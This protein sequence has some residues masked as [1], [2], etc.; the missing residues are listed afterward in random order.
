MTEIL[1]IYKESFFNHHWGADFA[2]QIISVFIILAIAIAALRLIGKKSIAQ[3]TLP[4]V[5]FV[6]I[7]TTTLGALITQPQALFI[8]IVITILIAL[9]IYIIELLQIKVDLIEFIFVG[10]PALL[11]K[12]GK[13]QTKQLKKSKMTLDM[14]E[15]QIRVK[16]IPSIAAC[17]TV[18][19]EPN[20][21]IGVE[22]F[23]EYEGIKK[24]YFDAAVKQIL[25]AINGSKYKEAEI[26]K[27][28][29]I[30]D[31]VRGEK[32]NPPKNL[33]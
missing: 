18:T 26:P 2:V 20:G 29:N 13:P 9:I 16:G 22:T 24:I 30:F 3:L 32:T 11:V 14:L 1:N 17:K 7:L 27:I 5:V 12:D 31:E 33:E 8:G 4:N 21:T 10:R 28:V 15:S 23:P 6:F 25:D 19:I